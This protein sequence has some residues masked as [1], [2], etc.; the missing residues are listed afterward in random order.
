M[1]TVYK[2]GDQGPQVGSIQSLLNGN[3]YPLT[4]DNDFGEATEQAIIAF[5]QSVGL[6][7]DGVVG[8]KTID[9]LRG[10]NIGRYLTHTDMQ[11]AAKQLEVDVA[12]IYAVRRIEGGQIGY[13]ADGRVDILFERHVMLRRLKH[14]GQDAA[15]AA[16][17][18]P[19]LVNSKPGGYKGGATE[20]YR[21]N[22]AC[23]IHRTSAMESCSWGLFQ[24][25]GYHWKTLGYASLDEFT[26]KMQQSEG[27]QLS[28]FCLFIAANPRL[29]KALKEKDWK[30][31]ARIYNGPSYRK[32]HYD[33]KL[34]LAYS[35][36]CKATNQ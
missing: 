31:F 4:V 9:A 1:Q 16:A 6:I 29:H 35:D 27:N 5:Q 17:Q 13:L 22:L 36:Y 2:R 7:A 18:Y 32:N 15:T 12:A 33:S 11:H 26:S 19:N 34:A 25:M 20:H 30:Q 3:S 10:K 23:D 28:A 8:Q 24:I 21:L 14:H